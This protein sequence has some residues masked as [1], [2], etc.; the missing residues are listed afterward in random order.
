MK[1]DAIVKHETLIEYGL[2]KLGSVHDYEAAWEAD[3]LKVAGKMFALLGDIGGRPIITLKCP[4][5]LAEQLRDANPE[6]IPGYYM[7][8]AHWNTLFLDGLLDKAFVHEMIDI[9]YQEV[10]KTL[11]KKV[12]LTLSAP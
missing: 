4:P 7:N 6:V 2:T 11:P 12:Q 10:L 5:A 8:K 3:R 9:S 1:R